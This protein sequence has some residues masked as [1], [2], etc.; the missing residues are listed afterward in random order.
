MTARVTTLCTGIT[1]G[2]GAEE[3]Q[4]YSER[5]RSFRHSLLVLVLALPIGVATPREAVAN[6]PQAPVSI[7]FVPGAVMNGGQQ[8][9]QV[10]LTP[11]AENVTHVKLHIYGLDGLVIRSGPSQVTLPSKN[12]RESRVDLLLEVN[13][14]GERRLV[15]IAKLVE[16]D[17]LRPEPRIASFIL[18]P[19]PRS[20]S[21]A[22]RGARRVKHPS[23]G[24]VIEV[25]AKER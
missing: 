7:S 11:H 5:R 3:R 18:N 2:K 14:P 17:G 19:S 21:A 25:P 12:G 9:V 4:L 1:M 15:V 23:G 13:G 8:R 6:Q 16:Q 22:P 10:L 20:P 24:T